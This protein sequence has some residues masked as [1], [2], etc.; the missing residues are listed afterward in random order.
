[1]LGTETG[2]GGKGFVEGD[3]K[4]LVVEEHINRNDKN[5]KNA[6]NPHIRVG[7]GENR[8]GAKEGGADI[9]R[10]IGRGREGVHQQ[11]ADGQRT[12]R[13][14]GNRCIATELHLWAII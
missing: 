2:G 11:I 7:E 14:N 3:G 6:A 12:H 4:N 13:E 9:A 1:M 5:R 10:Y 8:G